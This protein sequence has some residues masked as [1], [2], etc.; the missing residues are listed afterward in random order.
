MVVI[1]IND[2]HEC[3]LSSSVR[4]YADD[5]S[6][7]FSADNRATLEEKLN[8]DI[9]GVQKW[10]QSNKLTLN[11]KKTKYMIMGSHYRLRHLNEDLDIEVTNQQLMRVTTLKISGN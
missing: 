11:V 7:T 5:M 8:E 4:M 2:P 10:L 3:R 1:Y 6:L 9:N